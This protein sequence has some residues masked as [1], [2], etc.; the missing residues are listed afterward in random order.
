MSGVP[1]PVLP[2]T[3]PA[4]LLAMG[5]L[6]A[7]VLIV[8][9]YRIM[10]RR[11]KKAIRRKFHRFSTSVRAAPAE[12]RAGQR[13]TIPEALQAEITLTDSDWFG[14]KGRIVD[15]SPGG[16]GI[17]PDFPLKKVPLQT[18]LNNV[19]VN[20][21]EANFVVRQART[22]RIEHQTQKRLLGLQILVIDD[23]QNIELQRFMN[24]LQEFLRHGRT[25]SAH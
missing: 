9:A 12:L 6:L 24:Q 13:L 4:W 14:L 18:V 16:F 19:L 3:P 5:A 11:R 2:S 25:V 23:D 10:E 7:L 20:T 1:T 8:L 21:P 17:K 15:L 22:V